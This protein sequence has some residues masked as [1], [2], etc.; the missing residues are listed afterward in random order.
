[1]TLEN[2]KS[3]QIIA[4]DAGLVVPAYLGKGRMLALN[5]TPP[6]V[7]TYIL[8]D[9]NSTIA[10][11]D[12][13]AGKYLY[14]GY[15]SLVTNSA[16]GAARLLDIGWDAYTQEDGTAVAASGNGIHSAADV[17]A[18]GSFIPLSGIGV[19]KTKLFDSRGPGV[20]IR[21]KVTG[22]ALPAGTTVNMVMIFMG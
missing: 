1:M 14:I 9:I 2:L 6:V 22:A 10:L 5:S 18:A 7:G 13:P 8:G 19:T 16:F 12:V 21:A 3:R 17:S 4:K 20:R 11:L 15:L